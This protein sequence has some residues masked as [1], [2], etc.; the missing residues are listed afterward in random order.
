MDV[1]DLAQP[2]ERAAGHK[3]ERQCA[4]GLLAQR[5]AQSQQACALDGPRARDPRSDGIDEM[6]LDKLAHRVRGA[7]TFRDMAAELFEGGH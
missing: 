3:I 2:C 6:Q 5:R 7:H 4:A 1:V